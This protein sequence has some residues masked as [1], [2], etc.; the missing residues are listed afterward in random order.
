MTH[1]IEGKSLAGEGKKGGEGRRGD[2]GEERHGEAVGRLVIL[3]DF[4]LLILEAHYVVRILIF[5][6]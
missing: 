3:F 6:L 5:Y 4:F 2:R 1:R